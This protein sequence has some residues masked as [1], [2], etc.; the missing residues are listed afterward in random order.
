[1][2]YSMHA[3]LLGDFSAFADK[4]YCWFLR[5]DFENVGTPLKLKKTLWPLFMGGVQLPQGYTYF[6]EIVYFL[7]LSSQ[8]F[9]VLILSTS[10]R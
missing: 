7:R 2:E 6:E 3:I 9:L 1:M 10:E 4:I 5:C 8:K